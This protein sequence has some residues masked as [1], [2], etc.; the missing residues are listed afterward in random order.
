MSRAALLAAAAL[1]AFAA[2]PGARAAAA[3]PP[4]VMLVFD[5]FPTISLLDARGRIDAERYPNFA[6]FAR[7]G[8]W[9]PYATASVDETGRATEALLTGSTPERKRP[10]TVVANPDNL[11][12][13]LG[14]RY[15][16]NVSEE[17]TALC[18]KRYCPLVRLP[19]GEELRRDLSFGRV[20]RFRLWLRSVRPG[21]TPT[22][23]FKHLLLPHVP[24]RF[25]P[26]GRVY[27]R[28]R[29]EPI[30]AMADSYHERWLVDQTYQRHLLQLEF[31]DRLL[32][33]FVGRLRR[34]GLW[35]RSL[36]IL[37]ADN[38]E[39]FGLFG[40]RHVITDHKAANIA[41][42]PLFLKLP[43]QRHGRVIRSH[44]RT[45]D[46]V[47]TIAQVLGTR[48]PWRTQGKSLLGPVA[49]R[50]PQRVEM[51]QRSGRRFTLTMPQ[52]R[53]QARRRLREKLA[54]FGSGDEPPGVY[55]IGP[56]PEL[57]GS[58]LFSWPVTRARHT[59]AA[60]NG[61]ARCATSAAAR[62]WCP[63]SSPAGSPGGARPGSRPLA[64]AVNGW[65]VATAPTFRLP[66]D[67][68]E[69]FTAM[70]PDAFLHDGS[71]EVQ[72]LAIES[73]GRGLRLAR[74]FQE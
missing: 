30:R 10:R 27:S 17:A 42:T 53:R 32:G 21:R 71:N 40:D 66:G 7:T 38:G 44:A 3:Q 45:V 72:V 9:F 49:R 25:L 51:I 43:R 37:T 63:R 24:L 2:L 31:T 65:L 13:W 26:S 28:D 70:V 1:A 34:T 52:L 19:N 20:E 35:D 56:H 39:S 54:M 4:V 61:R 22:L 55:G 29:G 11:F 8:T 59:R 48:L 60:L 36:V 69:Y 58:P 74:I 73:R 16:M 23:Y 57:L 50:I 5:E 6:A 67:R 33:E 18:P 64:F 15:G 41:L 68:T 47:P 46:V 12:T 62:G 14:P